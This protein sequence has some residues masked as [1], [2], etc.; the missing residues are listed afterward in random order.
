MAMDEESN[1][2]AG[3]GSLDRKIPPDSCE[4]AVFRSH[5]EMVDLGLRCRCLFSLEVFPLPSD[6]VCVWG[7]GS[8][9]S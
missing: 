8:R 4:A 3:Q 6:N 1:G 9:S 5:T 2:I 7:V